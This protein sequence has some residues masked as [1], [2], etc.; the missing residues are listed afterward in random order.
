[1]RRSRT[2]ARKGPTSRG[3]TFAIFDLEEIIGDPN[4]MTVK[5]YQ[6]VYIEHLGDIFFSNLKYEQFIR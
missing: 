1:M 3:T 2:L 6:N 4:L 5:F